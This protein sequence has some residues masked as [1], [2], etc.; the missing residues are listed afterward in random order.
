MTV[1]ME[2][3]NIKSFQ[4]KF[5]KKP[6]KKS[7]KKSFKK[8]FKQGFKK[9]F[10]KSYKQSNTKK[11]VYW[12]QGLEAIR[13]RKEYYRTFKDRKKR[14]KKKRTLLYIFFLKKFKSLVD[15]TNINLL[16]IFLTKFG[17]IKANRKTRVNVQQ[18][19]KIAKAIRKARIEKLLPFSIKVLV[20]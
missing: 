5:F 18:H 14:T 15:Y 19:R 11:N 1:T 2:K 16:K 6:F 17:K 3:K 8:P 4:K 10:G 20:S 9:A 13:Q 12:I 7:F